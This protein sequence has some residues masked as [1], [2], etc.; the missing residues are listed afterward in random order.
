LIIGIDL[1]G[2]FC[3]DRYESGGVLK[4]VPLDGAR[5]KIKRMRAAG[6][7]V[8]FF[9]HRDETL[10]LDTI[11]WLDGLGVKHDGV[12][13]GKPHFDCYIGNEAVRFESWDAIDAGNL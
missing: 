6:H 10:K 8:I 4:C 9:T 7:K 12:I 3:T 5:E 2:T 13:F 11:Q 1:D